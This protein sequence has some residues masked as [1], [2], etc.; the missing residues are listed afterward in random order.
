MLQKFP[1]ARLNAFWGDGGFGYISKTPGKNCGLGGWVDVM[2]INYG[3]PNPTPPPSGTITL[4]VSL[5]DSY[6]DGWNSNIL[7]FM[8]NDVVI[9]TFGSNFLFGK[10]PVPN[11]INITI[12]N[13]LQTQIVVVR[14]GYYSN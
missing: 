14:L 5:S 4:S 13:N 8:Q 2:T 3:T 12:P 7:G 1:Q 11:P 6:G 10:S 9:A